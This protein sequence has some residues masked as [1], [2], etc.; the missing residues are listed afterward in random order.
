MN[1]RRLAL[2]VSAL[3]VGVLVFACAPA[4]AAAPEAPET[5]KASGVT[6]TSANLEGILNPGGT[7][8]AGWYFFYGTEISCLIGPAASPQ[9]PEVQGQALAESVEVTGLEPS[10]TYRF[11]MVATNQAGESTPSA[12]EASFTTLAAP[13]GL[14]G[15]TSSGVNSTAA[16]FEAQVNPNNQVT[17]CAIEYGS[18]NAYGAKAPCEP[19]SLKGFGNQR[20]SLSLTGLTPGTTHHF[21]FVVENAAKEKTEGADQTVT[22]LP[23][24]HTD[25]VSNIAATTATF[26]G[27]LT[28]NPVDTHYFF[29][30]KVGTE[31]A[32][33]S[34]TPTA[35]AGEGPGTPFSASTP[36]TGLR[37]ASQY[38]V[39]LVATN[40]FGSEPAAPVTF[41]TPPT[42]PTVASESTE[43]SGQQ[44]LLNA[45]IVPNGGSTTYQ[46]EY[47]ETSSYG[48]SIPAV[49]GNIGSSNETVAVPVA[50][51]SDLKASTI[52]HYRVVATNQYGTTDGPDQTLLTPPLLG[53]SNLAGPTGL[54]DGRVYEQVSPTFKNGNYVDFAHT[55]AFG[56]AEGGGD[57]V[58]YPVSGATGSAYSGTIA[59]DVSTRTPGV[60]WTTTQTSPRQDTREFS[61]FDE[62]PF[63]LIPSA[64]FTKFVFASARTYVS[65]DPRD[66]VNIYLSEDPS[67]EPTWLSRP[68]TSNPIPAPGSLEYANGY[69]VAGASPDL[70]SVYFAYMGTLLPE[71]AAR[72][73]YVG[74]GIGNRQAEFNNEAWGLY[75]WSGGALH[76]VG[77]LPDG[78]LS[79]FGAVPASFGLEGGYAWR[80]LF[81]ANDTDNWLSTDGSHAYFLSPDPLASEVTNGAGYACQGTP[82]QCTPEAPELYLREVQP[83]GGHKVT[84][85]SRSELP[86]HVGEPAPHGPASVS[87]TY[88]QGLET[89]F[90]FGSS[91]GSHVF[92]A[93]VDRLTPAAPEGGQLKEYDYDAGS[94]TLTYLPGVQGS[95]ATASADGSELLFV[96]TASAPTEL[97]LWREGPAG[98]TVT[99]IAAEVSS[100]RTARVSSDGSVFVFDTRAVVP[101]GFNNGGH[102][103][104]GNQ[105][106]EVYRYD[107]SQR[108]LACVSCPPKG[109][110]PIGDAEMSYNSAPWEP[111]EVAHTNGNASDPMTT[112][113]TRGISA[114]GSRIFFDTPNALVPQDTNGV[115]DVY[116][117]ENGNIYLI[118]SGASAEPSFYLDNSES[119]GDVFF[120]T[121]SGLVPGDTDEAYDV[122]DARIPRPGD[123]PPPAAVPCSGE[124]CQGP[125]ST[126]DLL[127]APASATFAGAG[128]LAPPPPGVQAKPKHKPKK[129]KPKKHKPKKHKPRKAKKKKKRTLRA[130]GH[131]VTIDVRDAR[132][133]GRGK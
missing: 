35:D 24:P 39:C 25:P 40:A 78:K 92:F 125:P 65:G 122:Y 50:E 13:P 74:N 101:G 19:A 58:V 105:P 11:C 9:E 110:T 56:L 29:A 91:D 21:R 48:T 45:Q 59:D 112:L 84:L 37:P 5:G 16:T 94:N 114:D 118:S 62:N 80:S 67:R 75:E 131:N 120:A 121:D 27:H 70:S 106:F 115:R 22:T 87:N 7:A 64:D 30:Y 23:T 126:P 69:I 109:V 36:A 1:A 132:P 6:A 10:A 81:Q 46:F 2:T 128:N 116:E 33:E 71:D 66:Y 47:G 129:H 130:R 31:C 51:P 38:A 57:A 49:A 93:S 15:E 54:P 111:D 44:V 42:S 95:I 20:V 17:S 14:E 124:V 104:Q 108:Q 98:G 133:N 113:D 107:V 63:A 28:L 83:G 102:D 61:I 52:Y 55:F 85:V 89:T 88:A 32:G 60:G 103:A 97:A 99:P 41:T 86:G 127:G 90:A 53:P 82:S 79:P 26:N 34:Q 77:T 18:T 76:E 12:N 8:K 68:Q 43:D 123:N 119:G 3:V 4:L 100:V 96:D 72:A 117:W 73:P